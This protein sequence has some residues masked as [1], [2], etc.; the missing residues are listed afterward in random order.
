[1]H[2]HTHANY[3][4]LALLPVRVPAANTEQGR[5]TTTVDK[6]HDARH[7]LH[8]ICCSWLVLQWAAPRGVGRLFIFWAALEWSLRSHTSL[9]MSVWIGGEWGGLVGWVV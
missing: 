7:G 6:R 4:K 5:E 3:M 2:T 8:S 1:M 9:M